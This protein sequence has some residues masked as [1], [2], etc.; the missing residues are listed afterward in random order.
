VL[1]VTDLAVR[2]DDGGLPVNG[3]SFEV[4][5]GEI[6][7]IAGVQGNGQSELCEALMGLRPIV[8]GMVTI[9]GRD[10]TRA[11][12]RG[13]CGMAGC[14]LGDRGAERA[15]KGAAEVMVPHGVPPF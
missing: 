12:P 13:R 5:A 15:R 4:R 10:P 1:A 11:T 8:A 9:G 3:L 2:G 14:A 7:G 6:L